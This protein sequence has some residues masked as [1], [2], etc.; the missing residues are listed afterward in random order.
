MTITGQPFT[1]SIGEIAMDNAIWSTA[2]FSQRKTNNCI[3]SNQDF[4]IVFQSQLVR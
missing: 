3:L 4:E 1:W 2:I